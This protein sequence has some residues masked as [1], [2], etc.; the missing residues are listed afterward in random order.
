MGD[1]APAGGEAAIAT[2]ASPWTGKPQKSPQSPRR[3]RS[4]GDHHAKTQ[5]RQEIICPQ[6]SQI[7]TDYRTRTRSRR[8]AWGDCLASGLQYPRK[9]GRRSPRRGRRRVATGVSPWGEEEQES[10]ASPRRGRSR[11][12]P[13]INPEARSLVTIKNTTTITAGLFCSCPSRCW[14]FP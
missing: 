13:S 5:R 3:G 10:L 8:E 4:S 1:E 14:K 6:I 9:P 2:G 12:F 7:Y 11:I